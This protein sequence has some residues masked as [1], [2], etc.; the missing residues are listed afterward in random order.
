MRTIDSTITIARPVA[1]VFGYFLDLDR[2]APE[3]D[4]RVESVIKDPP[5]PTGP[6]TTFRFR[7][8]TFGK[9]RETSTRFT[10]LEPCSRIAFVGKVGPLRPKGLFTFEESDGETTLNVRI[11]DTDPVA[12]LQPL[13][14][15]FARIGQKVWDERL[16]RIG[17]ALEASR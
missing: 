7:Q 17:A 6:G 16:R 2:H 10:A 5:G 3:T 1:E 4:P 14:P 12:P 8:K 11:A 15:L 9:V 13:A